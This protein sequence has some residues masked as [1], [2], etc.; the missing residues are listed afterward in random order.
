[1]SDTVTPDEAQ[2]VLDAMYKQMEDG[3]IPWLVDVDGKRYSTLHTLQLFVQTP[4][5]SKSSKK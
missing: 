1:M 3:I 2:K 4:N 5:S